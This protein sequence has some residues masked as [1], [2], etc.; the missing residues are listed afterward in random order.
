MRD[1]KKAF[2]NKNLINYESK[3]GT[4]KKMA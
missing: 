4:K 1:M 3:K 2:R